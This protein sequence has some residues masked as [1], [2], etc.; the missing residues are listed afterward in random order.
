MQKINWPGLEKASFNCQ[1]LLRVFLQSLLLASVS[2]A[3]GAEILKSTNNKIKRENS[4]FVIIHARTY[5][6]QKRE[7][8]GESDIPQKRKKNI[9][10]VPKTLWKWFQWQ[11]LSSTSDV[12]SDVRYFRDFRHG[13]GPKQRTH[14]WRLL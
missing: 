2:T 10:R 1:F 4:C 13:I 8:Y 3:H 6:P 9:N 11:K 12:G 5:I 14:K 7:K